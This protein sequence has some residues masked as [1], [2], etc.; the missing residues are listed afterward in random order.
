VDE[1]YAKGAY[2]VGGIVFV[3]AWIYAII[4]YGFFLGLGLG[5]IPAAFI[6]FIAGILWPLVVLALAAILLFFLWAL[7]THQ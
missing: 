4:T 7:K 1:D 5:W 3:L 6:G 2:I